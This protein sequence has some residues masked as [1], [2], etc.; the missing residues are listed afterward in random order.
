LS[1]ILDELGS[2]V[3]PPVHVRNAMASLHFNQVNR[4]FQFFLQWRV[5]TAA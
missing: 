3:S 2:V 5:S 1:A 4:V